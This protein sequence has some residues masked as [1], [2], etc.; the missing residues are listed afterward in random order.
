MNQVNTAR[1]FRKGVNRVKSR[2]EGKRAVGLAEFAFMFS[3][4]RDTAK[5]LATTGTLYT[6]KVGGR[7]LVPVSEL[8]R[9]ERHGLAKQPR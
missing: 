3:I 2:E 6:I 1:R 8:E 5:R 7:R 9:I 4:S